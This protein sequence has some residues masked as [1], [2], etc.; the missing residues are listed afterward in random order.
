VVR[1]W[2]EALNARDAQAL[3]RLSHD[4]VALEPTDYTVPAGT[5]YHGHDGIHSLIQAI[6]RRFPNA[7]A[8]LRSLQDLESSVLVLWKVM[9]DPA[10]DGDPGVDRAVLF[11]VDDGRVRRARSYLSAT[12]AL[13]A[14]TRSARE[15]FHALFDA[16][17]EPMLLIDADGLIADGNRSARALLELGPEDLGRRSVTQLVGDT[18][19]WAESWRRLRQTGRALGTI[20]LVS[21]TGER[22]EMQLS[23]TADYQPGRHLLVLRE[24]LELPP[25]DEPLLTAREREIFELLADGLTA[26][27]IAETLVLSP[28]TVRTHVQNAVAKLGA[29][30]RVQAVALAI[31]R[32][33]ITVDPDATAAGTASV[34]GAGFEPA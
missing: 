28:A 17:V 26:P 7:R 5:I 20:E 21:T 14:A 13:D 8:E 10:P 23:A 34:A 19:A 18:A 6:D 3:C 2:L 30:T 9:R 25:S 12:E 4:D 24:P 27:K 33:E 29:T 1:S 31:T 32:G 16:V 22:T 11:E 15:A